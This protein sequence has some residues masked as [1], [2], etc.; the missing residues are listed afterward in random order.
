MNTEQ[1][2]VIV[3]NL[4]LYLSLIHSACIYYKTLQYIYHDSICKKG[5]IN[6]SLT[7]LSI[8]ES[9]MSL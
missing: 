1:F 2:S 9:H 4:F 8:T 3:S 5:I 6:E 7:I